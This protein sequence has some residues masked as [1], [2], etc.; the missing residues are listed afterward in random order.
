MPR[1][2]HEYLAHPSINRLG[3]KRFRHA[4]LVIRALTDPIPLN[5]TQ[6]FEVSY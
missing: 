1:C 5:E 2:L 6:P 3:I 4:I